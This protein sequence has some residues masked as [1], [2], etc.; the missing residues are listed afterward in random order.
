LATTGIDV[1]DAVRDGSLDNLLEIRRFLRDERARL[2]SHYSMTESDGRAISRW[3]VAYHEAGH[4]VVAVHMALPL[5]YATLGESGS[6]LGANAEVRLDGRRCPR[7]VL[8]RSRPPSKRWY[9]AHPKAKR[10]Q[11]AHDAFARAGSAA[12]RRYLRS[13]GVD[14]RT[15][16]ESEWVVFPEI[17]ESLARGIV[18]ARWGEVAELAAALL[19]RRF[20]RQREVLRV[21]SQ[22]R[23]SWV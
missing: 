21:M 10:W 17:G 5:L 1:P 15:C 7:F 4:A 9:A 23:W 18:R 8:R 14:P 11:S 22:A 19:E 3:R 13:L 12:E 2:R 6:A 20:L 16:R